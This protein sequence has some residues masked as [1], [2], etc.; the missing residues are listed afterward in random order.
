MSQE[1]KPF[2]TQTPKEVLDALGANMTT[3]L[4]SAK[5]EQLL[6]QYGPNSLKQQEGESIWEKI[7]E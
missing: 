4:S 3:G 1:I 2:F 7:K 6:N 5:A